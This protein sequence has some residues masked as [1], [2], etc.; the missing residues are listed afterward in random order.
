MSFRNNLNSKIQALIALRKRCWKQCKKLLKKSTHP[1]EQNISS[2]PA[3]RTKNLVFRTVSL[4][5]DNVSLQNDDAI[6]NSYTSW[7]PNLEQAW[8]SLD[9]AEYKLTELEEERVRRE[10]R[11][12]R[13]RN[14]L[15]GS[16]TESERKNLRKQARR[17]QSLVEQSLRNITMEQVAWQ[18]EM[19]YFSDVMA[20]AS[21]QI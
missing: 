16:L 19:N 21:Q 15:R 5:N 10:K 4:V 13:T 9:G 17:Q 7:R 11:L 2:S 8:S 6:E 14:S 1:S 12:A 3:C 18:R 20:I